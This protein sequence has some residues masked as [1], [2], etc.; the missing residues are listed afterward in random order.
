LTDDRVT[1]GLNYNFVGKLVVQCLSRKLKH[2]SVIITVDII[3]RTMY[4]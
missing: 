2:K 1:L 4:S 3:L